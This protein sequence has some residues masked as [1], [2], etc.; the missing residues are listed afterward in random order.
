MKASSFPFIF[1]AVLWEFGI[2]GCLAQT[3]APAPTPAPVTLWQFGTTVRLFPGE[4]TL[5]LVPL[6]T[7]EDSSETTFLY[8]VE[9]PVTTIITNSEAAFTTVTSASVASRTIVASASGWVEPFGSLDDVVSCGFTDAVS[10]ECANVDNGSTFAIVTGTPNPKVLAVS[11]AP[12]TSGATEATS[13]KTTSETTT[14]AVFTILGTLVSIATLVGLWVFVRFRRRRRVLDE[15]KLDAYTNE[16]SGQHSDMRQADPEQVLGYTPPVFTKQRLSPNRSL[17]ASAGGPS[18]TSP[19][20]PIPPVAFTKQQLATRSSSYYRVNASSSSPHSAS[21]SGSSSHSTSPLTS[22]AAL[23]SGSA[24]SG[25]A[26]AAAASVADISTEDLA[27]VLY[28]RMQAGLG[29]DPAAASA[30]ES[31]PHAPP[32]AYRTPVERR[33]RNPFTGGP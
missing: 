11:A 14:I 7:A 18:S 19:P 31:D 2:H 33:A 9:V 29:S 26:L 17:D 5:P 21:P 23:P 28:E 4:I 25:S 22:N 3:P 16:P 27:R 10:G 1:V 20:I 24:S 8:Q 6:G 30:G 15:P 13:K 32:P 12:T